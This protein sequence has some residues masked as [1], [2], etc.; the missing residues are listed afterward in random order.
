MHFWSYFARLFFKSCFWRARIWCIL[1]N[2]RCLERAF[3]D[4]TNKAFR[5]PVGPLQT[6]VLH[7]HT[8]T[9][10]V[11][12]RGVTV[13]G[14]SSSHVT[15]RRH[16]CFVHSLLGPIVRYRFRV[17]FC[18]ILS[19]CLA[20]LM[21]Q[22]VEET[23]RPC[24]DVEVAFMSSVPLPYHVSWFVYETSRNPSSGSVILKWTRRDRENS[25]HRHP[26]SSPGERTNCTH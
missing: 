10:K 15:P 8:H 13:V 4:I 1:Q 26:H 25:V 18:S 9:P 20:F 3:F 22:S 19:A 2:L 7:T 12:W 17:I 24:S 6:F 5:P 14:A 23:H 21:C 11:L 16:Y